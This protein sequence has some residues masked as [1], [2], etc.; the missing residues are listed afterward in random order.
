MKDIGIVICNYNKKDYLFKCIKSVF[1][2]SINNFDVYVV[3]NA[4]TD[5]SV[6]MLKKNFNDNVNIIEN[7]KNLGG[8]GGFNTGIKKCLKFGY[9][10]IMC[11]DNDIIFDKMAIE[12]LYN[13]LEN[14]S[15][16]G[17]A[18][19]K[20]C[21]MDSPGIIQTYGAKL[22]FKRY[23]MVDCYKG[24]KDTPGLPEKVYSD[25]LPACAL[26][27]R[28][29]V[30]LK[31]GIMPEEV[32]IYWDDMEWGYKVNLAGYKVVALGSS[33]VWHN[34]NSKNPTTFSKYYMW[35]NR[36]RFF[37][38]YI[39]VNDVEKFAVNILKEFYKQV[40]ACNIKGE[41]SI[42]KTMMFAY[43]DAIHNVTGKAQDYKIMERDIIEN[44]LKNILEGKNKVL[45][46]FNGNYEALQNTIKR[47]RQLKDTIKIYISLERC[48]VVEQDVQNQFPGIEIS[49]SSIEKVTE[50]LLCN[51]ILELEGRYEEIIYID[52]WGNIITDENTFIKC[53]CFEENLKLFIEMNK[54]LFIK[55]IS[56]AGGFR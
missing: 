43:D 25:Y 46:Y 48:N 7:S 5:G 18:G 2:S 21:T 6:D 29:E 14:N 35:R 54:S 10:Y 13:Y 42:I 26:M 16:T 27:V 9:K 32:F 12:I 44:P 49:D 28:T 31:T 41:T 3:D 47:I 17:M 19:S 45:I 8:A 20:I 55:Q 52:G 24:Y 50:I 53:K 51:H 33:K 30:I 39:N 37:A 1:N 36:I 23:R 22:D 4:S 38:K 34:G 15:S 40:Y 11:V 56:N